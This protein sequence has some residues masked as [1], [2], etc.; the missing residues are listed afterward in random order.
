MP[1]ELLTP[2]TPGVRYQVQLRSWVGGD[3]TEWRL[4][5]LTGPGSVRNTGPRAKRD[6]VNGD[7][8]GFDTRESLD[9]S[10]VFL[11]E[12]ADPASGEEAAEEAEGAWS[13]DGY[14]DEELHMLMPHRGHV[15]YVGRPMELEVVRVH[16]SPERAVIQLEATFEA[17]DP[18]ARTA[19]PGGS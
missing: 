12:F 6:F 16:L 15:Y 2:Y 1:G 5:R 4:R 8:A 3:G 19:P 9:V 11:G 10:M 13:P 7:A 18:V 14:D 17:L